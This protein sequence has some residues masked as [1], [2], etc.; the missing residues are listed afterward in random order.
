[1]A[2]LLNRPQPGFSKDSW[3]ESD[4]EASIALPTELRIDV[5]H[6]LGSDLVGGTIRQ[7]HLIDPSHSPTLVSIESHVV[8]DAARR[9]NSPQYLSSIRRRKSTKIKNM[10]THLAKKAHRDDFEV[11]TLK[12]VEE[13]REL[14]VQLTDVP[15]E[16]NTR[17]ILRQIRDTFLDGGHEQYRDAKARDLV[18]SIF[19]RLAEADEVTPDDVGEVWDEIYDGGISAR[20][21]AVFTVVEGKEEADG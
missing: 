2:T 17:E 20:I 16:G 10:F 6:E 3:S 9:L 8:T 21:P 4:T 12:V 11:F 18:A 19:E 5:V 15:R 1:M 7:E 13:I 14:L